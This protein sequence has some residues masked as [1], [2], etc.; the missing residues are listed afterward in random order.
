MFYRETGQYKTN[1]AADMALFPIRQD[2]VAM[3][4]LLVAAFAIVPFFANQYW[5]S[6]CILRMAECF[7]VSPEALRLGA[8]RLMPLGLQSKF[9]AG[10]D[11]CAKS[12]W[13]ASS[14]SRGSSAFPKERPRF[15]GGPSRN[16]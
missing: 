1:Y 2:R 5:L 9:M 3:A 11:S 12:A 10:T 4:I 13:N 16:R 6:A 15:S 7:I 8:S 14:D